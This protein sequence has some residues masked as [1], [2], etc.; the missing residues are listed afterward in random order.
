M[1]ALAV[2][3]VAATFAVDYG[4]TARDDGGV[5][6]IIQI[7][8]HLAEALRNGDLPEGVASEIVPQVQNVRAFRIMIG[9]DDLPRDDLPPA[10]TRNQAAKAEMPL[11]SLLAADTT[12]DLRSRYGFE[13]NP[14]Y[15]DPVAGP[16]PERNALQNTAENL[17]NTA[18]QAVNEAT[19]RAT[20]QFQSEATRLQ[21]GLENRVQDGMQN[22]GNALRGTIEPSRTQP[23]L[24]QSNMNSGTDVWQ[25]YANQP[26]AHNSTG[27]NSRFNSQ[28]HANPQQHAHQHYDPSQPAGTAGN[29]AQWP[30]QANHF[31]NNPQ[32]PAANAGQQGPANQ[33]NYANQPAAGWPATREQANWQ[34]GNP[35]NNT[36]NQQQAQ[37]N[38]QQA[39][40]PYPY[41]GQQQYQ[42]PAQQQQPYWQQ[43]QQQAPQPGVPYQTPSTT[44]PP[45]YAPNNVPS[46]PYVASN[47]ALNQPTNA[48]GIAPPSL[49]Q[50]TPPTTQVAN[51]TVEHDHDHAAEKPATGQGQVGASLADNRSQQQADQ[52]SRNQPRNTSESRADPGTVA[53]VS[54]WLLLLSISG[55]LFLGY[56]ASNFQKQTRKMAM[57]LRR[58]RAH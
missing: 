23:S 39:Q 41:S 26:A 8:P 21:Q 15:A 11:S 19:N 45:L 54:V 10:A 18:G 27:S 35:V 58:S 25:N 55:N 42:N 56:I 46:N 53:W 13:A 50:N 28:Q 22:A 32:Q 7:E 49:P 57:Q 16:T 14:R 5:E 2:V 48:G 31:Q 37:P 3:L 38:Q 20:T 6:Y 30:P 40:Q 51:N 52:P 34:A 4:W 24:N 1:N 44:A 33:G 43:P 29:P 9:E 12:P 36:P 17:R 47:P